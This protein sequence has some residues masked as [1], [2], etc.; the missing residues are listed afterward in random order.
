MSIRSKAFRILG[1]KMAGDYEL[2]R[3]M[4]K[5]ATDK[6]LSTHPKRY[7]ILEQHDFSRFLTP[8]QTKEFKKAKK[9]Y[10]KLW[11]EYKKKKHMREM[12]YSYTELIPEKKLCKVV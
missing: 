4:D 1:G 6:W 3:E 11:R 7:S 2:M 9:E 12:R 10:D 8:K 5:K